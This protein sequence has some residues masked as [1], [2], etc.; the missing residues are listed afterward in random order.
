MSTEPSRLSFT[1]SEP[2]TIALE[3]VI[4]AHTA[5]VLDE[6]A[7][8]LGAAEDVHVDLSGV[9]FVDSSGLRA[10]VTWHES[11]ADA[12]NRLEMSSPT[13]AVARLFEIAGIRDHL[14]LR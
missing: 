10:L 8:E 13:S 6:K 12:G 5:P 1:A 4:D 9:D 11:L 7:E 2:R 3:G 14:H